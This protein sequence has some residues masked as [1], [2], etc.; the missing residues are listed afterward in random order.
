MAAWNDAHRAV[1]DEAVRVVPGVM[2]CKER[3]D[4]VG[5]RILVAGVIET[6]QNEHDMPPCITWSIMFSAALH[7]CVQMASSLSRERQESLESML[8]NMG[9]IAAIWQTNAAG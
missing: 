5:A 6:A 4:H 9:S 7:W 1:F 3:S 2:A 8:Q